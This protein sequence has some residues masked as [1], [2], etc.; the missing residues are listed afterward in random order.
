MAVAPESP[1]AACLNKIKSDHPENQQCFECGGGGTVWADASHGIYLCFFCS[2]TYRQLGTHLAFVR[3]TDMDEWLP[4]HL[5]QMKHGGNARAK[6]FFTEKQIMHLP[7]AKR[8]PTQ[9]ALMYKDMLRAEAE[10]QPF[11][12]EKWLQEHPPPQPPQ[13]QPINT[14]TTTGPATPQGQSPHTP[15]SLTKKKMSWKRFCCAQQPVD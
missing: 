14:N 10:N 11:D 8:Y 7:P 6:Q 1:T 13:L 15:N 12:E 4:V 2:G 3:S 5:E 9:P